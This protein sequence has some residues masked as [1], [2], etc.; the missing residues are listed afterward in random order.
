MC[1][2]AVFCF[3]LIFLI[4]IYNERSDIPVLLAE[5]R[6]LRFLSTLARLLALQTP[7]LGAKLG[8]AIDLPGVCVTETVMLKRAS[9]PPDDYFDFFLILNVF[10]Q[11]GGLFTALVNKG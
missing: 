9:P 5:M 6:S 8:R 1:A 11:I 7:M 3:N 10:N 2:V 4:Y